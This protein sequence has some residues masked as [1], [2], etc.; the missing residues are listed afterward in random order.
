MHIKWNEMKNR[1]KWKWDN[2]EE[3]CVQ[4][5]ADK[6]AA[7][8]YEEMCCKWLL[9]P[10]W[11]RWNECIFGHVTYSLLCVHSRRSR[12][13]CLLL[14]THAYS[15]LRAQTYT[16][17]THT[18]FYVNK[19]VHACVCMCVRSSIRMVYALCLCTAQV[20]VHVCVCIC[21]R[22]RTIPYTFLTVWHVFGC[23]CMWRSI[24]ANMHLMSYNPLFRP[25]FTFCRC[26][27]VL[28]RIHQWYYRVPQRIKYYFHLHF[29][30]LCFIWSEILFKAVFQFPFKVS[31]HFRLTSTSTVVILS[32][33]C[34][35]LHWP[36]RFS[37]G[38]MFFFPHLLWIFVI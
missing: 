28:S 23:T 20:C 21:D 17:H 30:P 13:Q 34:V 9:W 10:R 11:A 12:A 38:T 36:Q 29:F 3:H 35:W 5:N 19:C 16:V 14:R 8:A 1:S 2:V 24:W 33:Y 18:H 4:L 31:Y 22:Q 37:F 15:G 26:F 32:F 6:C 7:P 27:W 25:F